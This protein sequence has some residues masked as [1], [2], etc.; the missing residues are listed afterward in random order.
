[1][2]STG[3]VRKIDELGRIV[4]PKE[5]R[6]VLGIHSN[7]DLEI[8]IDDMKIVL[9][10]YEKSDNIL[11]YSNNVVKII[12]EKLNIKVFVTNKEKIITIG[13]FKNKELDSKLL[14]LIEE[15]KRYESINKETINKISAYFVIYPIIVESDILGLLMFTKETSFTNEEKILTNIILKLIENR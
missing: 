14:E 6:N 5:I 8:F 2:K 3:I 1:M 11:N 7:D 10:K 9:T 12:E 13:N 15:R 4:I